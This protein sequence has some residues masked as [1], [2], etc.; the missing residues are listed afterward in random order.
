MTLTVRDLKNSIERIANS[1]S[2]NDAS[3]L[4]ALADA[5]SNHEPFPLQSLTTKLKQVVL[6]V[7]TAR[8]SRTRPNAG[9][10]RRVTASER[11]EALARHRQALTSTLYDD[12][13][14]REAF[15]KAKNDTALDAKRAARLF[16]RVVGPINFEA[17]RKPTIF[18]QLREQRNTMVHR[19]RRTGRAPA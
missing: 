17:N 6:K 14:F 1:S 19:Q 8:P 7:P 3:E 16:E 10:A 18:K 5:L 4:R 12:D 13:A 9:T 2:E 15:E 11:D